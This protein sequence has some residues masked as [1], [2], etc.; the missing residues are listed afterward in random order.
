MCDVP[1]IKNGKLAKFKH[2]SLSVHDARLFNAL[3]KSLRELADVK[4]DSFK[5]ALDKYLK[6]VPDEPQLSGYTATQ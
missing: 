5:H 4:L 3:P 2:A 6:C 1:R